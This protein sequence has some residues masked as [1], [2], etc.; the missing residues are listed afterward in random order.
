MKNNNQLALI[1]AYYLSRS[2][3]DAYLK[4]GY[5]SFNKAAEGIGVIL[6]VKPNTIKNMRDE[7]DPYHANDRI[8]W[9]RDLRGSRLKVMNSF[10]D[11][12]D[13]TLFE[14]VKSILYDK[15]FAKTEEYNDI[16]HI[17]SEDKKL[18]FKN[19]SGQFIFLSRGLTGRRAESFFV[20][21]FDNKRTQFKGALTDKRNDGCGYDFEVTDGS[22]KYFIEVKGLS[23][24][25]GGILFTS[26]EW[27]TALE[28]RD[29]YYLVLVRSLEH[30]PEIKIL[31]DPTGSLKA[32]KNIFTT[33]QVSWS[34]SVKDLQQK[35]PKNLLN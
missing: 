33:V 4:L 10:Q 35:C 28:K 24:K 18:S 29:N 19:N 15:D 23:Q 2:D 14:I 22:Q 26:K 9:Q 32:K 5:S 8:G 20:D 6:G 3:K 11:T 34:V 27:Q 21:S 16:Q 13:L 1:V 17:F 31:Q 7:F 12:D 25:D 30:M